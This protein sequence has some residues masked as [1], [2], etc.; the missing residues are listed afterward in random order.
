MEGEMGLKLGC[1]GL[2][3]AV[4][5]CTSQEP[6]NINKGIPSNGFLEGQAQIKKFRLNAKSKVVLEIPLRESPDC[7]LAVVFPSSTFAQP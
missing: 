5:N 6:H 7:A 4:T 1:S 2:V 3:S